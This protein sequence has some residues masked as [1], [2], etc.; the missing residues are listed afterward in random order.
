MF[1]KIHSNRDPE[2]TIWSE[3]NNEFAPYISKANTGFSTIISAYPKQ[4]F[5]GM[6]LLIIV[7]AVLSFTVFRNTDDPLAVKV[8]GQVRITPQVPQANMLQMID[9]MEE[10]LLIQKQLDSIAAKEVLSATDS[11]TITNGIKRLDELESI[12]TTPK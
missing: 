5:V 4:I 2:K 7:S 1:K 6:M 12:L 10:T 11:L 9:L 8:S 3:L